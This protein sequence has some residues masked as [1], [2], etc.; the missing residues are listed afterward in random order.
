MP[1]ALAAS[2]TSV[3]GAA[4]ISRPSIESLMG[5]AMLVRGGA[6][7]SV[8]VRFELVAEFFDDRNRRHRRGVAQRAERAAQHVLRNIADQIDIRLRALSGMKARENLAQ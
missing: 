5:S 3:P 8:Q 7:L 2:M 6:L 1:A 4:W